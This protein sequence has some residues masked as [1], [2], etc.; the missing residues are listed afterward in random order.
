MLQ[1]NQ[2]G[3]TYSRVFE[4]VEAVICENKPASLPGLNSSTWGE[5]TGELPLQY[6]QKTLLDDSNTLKLIARV[7][8]L[9]GAYRLN[10]EVKT[11]V[12]GPAVRNR[13]G[14]ISFHIWAEQHSSAGRKQRWILYWIKLWCE[15]ERTQPEGVKRRGGGEGWRQLRSKAVH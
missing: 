6:G 5:I 7:S 14:F 4:V 8:R 15:G 3:S 12:S 1:Y 9:N 10:A 13:C 11:W 2:T